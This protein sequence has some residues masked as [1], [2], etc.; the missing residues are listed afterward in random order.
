MQG[1]DEIVVKN[2]SIKKRNSTDENGILLYKIQRFLYEK[3][4]II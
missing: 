1:N 4:L 3:V 2:T